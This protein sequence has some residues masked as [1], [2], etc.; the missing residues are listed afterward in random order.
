MSRIEEFVN[1]IIGTPE[2][3]VEPHG[4]AIS[5]MFETV[6]KNYNIPELQPDPKSEKEKRNAALLKRNSKDDIIM[7]F[8]Q[9]RLGRRTLD[10]LDEKGKTTQQTGYFYDVIDP[11][12]PFLRVGVDIRPGIAELYST[13]TDGI[14]EQ[15]NY[16]RQLTEKETLAFLADMPRKPGDLRFRVGNPEV[17][18]KLFEK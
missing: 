3:P 12:H 13:T 10:I 8:G 4:T 17:I 14:S 11:Q 5:H 1:R 9:K 16:S 2:R 7:H 6:F 15:F 18:D